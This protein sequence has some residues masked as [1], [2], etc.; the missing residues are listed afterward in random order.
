VKITVLQM[1]FSTMVNGFS[2]ALC[3]AN[4][5]KLPESRQFDGRKYRYFPLPIPFEAH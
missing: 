3:C 1:V 5:K 4:S 2:S